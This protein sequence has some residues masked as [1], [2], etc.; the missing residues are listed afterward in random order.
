MKETKLSEYI[1]WKIRITRDTAAHD[2]YNQRLYEGGIQAYEDILAVIRCKCQCM[3]YIDPSDMAY[4][5]EEEKK[6]KE[7]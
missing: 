3:G 6:K 5:L 2:G 1:T 4:I 7:E